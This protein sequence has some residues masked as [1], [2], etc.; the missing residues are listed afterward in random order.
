[1]LHDGNHLLQGGRVAALAAE[2]EQVHT[3]QP[4]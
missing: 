4:I 2:A 3:S 1:M